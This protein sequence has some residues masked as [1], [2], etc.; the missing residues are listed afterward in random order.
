MLKLQDKGEIRLLDPSATEQ[1]DTSSS[2]IINE[3][4][5]LSLSMNSPKEIAKPL[6]VRRKSKSRLDH[7]FE[8]RCLVANDVTF[9]LGMLE[10]QLK[11]QFDEVICVTDGQQAI[12]AV[13]AHPIQYFSMIILDINMPRKGGV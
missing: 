2:S 1:S 10:N 7:I 9:L 5:I 6:L 13:M 8:R 12:D 4:N 11:K 3:E